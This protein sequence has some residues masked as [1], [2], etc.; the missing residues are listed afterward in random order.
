MKIYYFWVLIIVTSCSFF[1]YKKRREISSIP[2][3]NC[4]DGIEAM[5]SSS[6]TI[7]SKLKN[8][9]I[10]GDIRRVVAGDNAVYL[11][12]LED[13]TKAIFKPE[14]DELQT[15][16]LSEIAAF[17]ISEAFEFNLVPPTVEREVFGETGSFQLFI[18]RARD[19]N[20]IEP[21]PKVEDYHK[22]IVFDYLIA[23]Y[24]R[25]EGNLL[26]DNDQNLF[27]ID[28]GYSFSSAFAEDDNINI[29]SY[30]MESLNRPELAVIK[31]K[32]LE[33]SDDDL[34]DLVAELPLELAITFFKRFGT[35]KKYLE[36]EAIRMRPE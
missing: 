19:G 6:R 14:R 23:E 1:D 20:L 2:K 22:N 5:F 33:I 30:V 26:L 10:V 27:L 35:L 36:A 24:D 3:I 9:K 8:L 12:T 4:L 11:V 7:T 18:G 32:I 25:H 13:G 15:E 21:I 16:Y 29:P 17:K 31:S 28:H 34:F